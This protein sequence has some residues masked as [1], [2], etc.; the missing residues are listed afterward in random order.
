MI[1]IL[2]H[3]GSHGPFILIILSIYLLWDHKILLFY[4]VIGIFVNMILNI[5]LK[6]IIQEPRPIFDDKKVSLEIN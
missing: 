5:I 6:G 1:S 2:N 4:Y 3:L